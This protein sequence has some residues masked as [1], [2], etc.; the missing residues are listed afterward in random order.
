MGHA[1]QGVDCVREIS[2][3]RWK[4]LKAVNTKQVEW[5]AQFWYADL[6]IYFACATVGVCLIKN[7]WFMLSDL[8]YVRGR[9]I[10]VVDPL[11]N[12]VTGYVRHFG[13]KQVPEVCETWLSFPTSWGNTL[14]AMVATGF[15][16]GYCLQPHFWYYGC[17]SFGTPPLA[18]RLGVMAT[19][20]TPF[21]FAL[22]GKVNF[23]A[24][25]LGISYEKLNWL[26]QFSS[27]AVLVLL[28]IHTIPF[29]WQPLHDG[30]Y[31][32]LKTTAKVG[33]FKNGIPPLVLLIL[34]CLLFKR[35]IRNKVY[36]VAFHFHW[37]IAVGYFATLTVHVWNTMNMQKY[38]WAT[39]AVWMAQWAWRVVAKLVRPTQG[40]LKSYKARL[41]KVSDGLFEVSVATTKFKWTPGQHCYLRFP[42]RHILQN[43]PFSI[44]SVVEDEHLKFLIVPKKG[45]TRRL[46]NELSESVDK[47]VIID[48]PYG[49]MSR[50]CHAF[51]KVI[52]VTS[53]SGITA[54][55]PY[56][57]LLCKKNAVEAIH[58]VWVVKHEDD[59]ETALTEL[60]V[61]L[62][63]FQGQANV[64]IYVAESLGE[65][66]FS[67]FN[68][69]NHKPNVHHVMASLKGH[70]LRRNM[71][72][73]SGSHLMKR[74]VSSAVSDYQIAVMNGYVEEVF[75][76][77]E[78]FGW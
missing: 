60:S 23:I 10:P 24:T 72:I 45:L 78:T 27:L 66:K 51:D 35:E 40:F 20:L 15:F 63:H 56:F 5:M 4:A 31:L 52:L 17:F 68:V 70:L 57:S 44:A 76:H 73:S 65:K 28:L 41:T 11:V 54:V 9:R 46:Y 42:G 47:S 8:R 74:A 12:I 18:V 61:G 55:L 34:L 62:Q 19:A 39:L 21:V 49:G 13:Y 14:Y 64:D 77:S 75:L 53:G 1:Y 22:S 2:S 16:L 43:H 30:G 58:L 7:A 26:H 3:P 59:I 29:I 71:V 32:Y 33:I 6:P 37:I 38:M 36:E 69:V 50:D 67:Q 48:G 25:L